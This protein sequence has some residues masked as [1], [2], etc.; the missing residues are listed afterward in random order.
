MNRAVDLTRIQCCF[1]REPSRRPSSIDSIAL[2]L[3]PFM[4]EVYYG[5]SWVPDHLLRFRWDLRNWSDEVAVIR[6]KS[7]AVIFYGQ[8]SHWN[9]LADVARFA[10]A[11]NSYPLR[12]VKY[13]ASCIILY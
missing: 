4:V 10:P 9:T 11:R 7:E 5:S 2:A 13:I 8:K 12:D 3:G 1:R 6:L